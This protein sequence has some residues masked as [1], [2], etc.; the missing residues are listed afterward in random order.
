M[1]LGCDRAS[2]TSRADVYSVFLCS[3]MRT[4]AARHWRN[5]RAIAYICAGDGA[6]QRC[7]APGQAWAAC[8]P[9]AAGRGLRAN[10]A[11]ERIDDYGNRWGC[12]HSGANAP[13]PRRVPGQ[14]DV[15]RVATTDGA[16]GST[17]RERH[18]SE[19]LVLV[20]VDDER[21]TRFLS[22]QDRPQLAASDRSWEGLEEL[23]H[24]LLAQVMSTPA[25]PQAFSCGL[26]DRTEVQVSQGW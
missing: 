8:L 7:H 20:A 10:A 17:V 1:R 9:D 25:V 14:R 16:A 23:R 3:R 11:S 6:R 24:P 21:T 19:F 18:D 22:A 13:T 5:W 12:G 4:G 15:V 2:R 26:V